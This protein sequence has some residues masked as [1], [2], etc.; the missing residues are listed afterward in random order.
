MG[1][2][3]SIPRKAL[4][5]MVGLAIVLGV[6]LA[7]STPAAAG[8]QSYTLFGSRTGWG[9]NAT[10]EKSPGPVLTA[11]LSDTVAVTVNSTDARTHTWYLDYNNDSIWNRTME[12]G[13]TFPNATG[14]AVTITFIANH[15]GAFHYRSVGVRDTAMWGNFTISPA[16]GL[17]GA[18]DNTLLIV[19]GV[20]VVIIAVLAIA[21]MIWRR[22]G[23]GPTEPPPPP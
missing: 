22:K 2:L 18:T 1:S 11:A 12:P 5:L 17:F 19:V 8:T 23:K 20:I 4:V 6:S 7:F 3:M 10:N 21:A 16:G 15:T 13:T 14:I 9:T